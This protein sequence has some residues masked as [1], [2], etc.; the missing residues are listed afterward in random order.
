M[1]VAW[2]RGVALEVD[3]RGRLQT[4]VGGKSTVLVMVHDGKEVP[5]VTLG[6][7]LVEL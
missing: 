6:L 3:R 7:W 2:T 1:S 5:R 4:H